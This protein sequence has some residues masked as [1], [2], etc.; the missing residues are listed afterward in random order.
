MFCHPRCTFLSEGRRENRV[1]LPC[2]RA[3][4]KIEPSSRDKEQLIGRNLSDLVLT[5]EWEEIDQRRVFMEGLLVTECH[6]KFRGAS[7]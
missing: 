7:T 5:E 6:S 3:L 2:A 1:T 4:K